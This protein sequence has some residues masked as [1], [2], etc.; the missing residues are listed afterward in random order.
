M[1]VVFVFLRRKNAGRGNISGGENLGRGG[2][3]KGREGMERASMLLAHS[4][5]GEY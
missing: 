3:E 1:K 5:L 4:H 2:K